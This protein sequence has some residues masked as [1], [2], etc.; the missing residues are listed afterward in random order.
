M[1]KKTF[2]GGIDSVLG[3]ASR[4]ESSV[5]AKRKPDAPQPGEKRATFH[6]NEEMLEKVKAIAYW[7]RLTIKE[8]VNDA[9]ANYIAKYEQEKG[10]IE[11]I[12]K[13]RLS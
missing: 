6:I 9:F 11:P 10:A 7:E 4:E 8:I 5:Q 3:E 2:R 1:A 12:P 13:K